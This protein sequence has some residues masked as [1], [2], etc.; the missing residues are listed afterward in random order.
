MSELSAGEKQ[1]NKASA[2]RSTKRLT[3]KYGAMAI[4]S[5]IEYYVESLFEES[6]ES[7]IE[8]VST[9]AEP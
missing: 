9:P 7:H 8:A 2:S 4:G 1:L 6:A 3:C 5:V